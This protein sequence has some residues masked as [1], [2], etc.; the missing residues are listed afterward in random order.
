MRGDRI[1]HGTDTRRMATLDH[2][3]DRF[4]PQRGTFENKGEERTVLACAECNERRGAERVASMPKELIW[5]K[6]HSPPRAAQLGQSREMV[7]S[8][9]VEPRFADS[10]SAVLPS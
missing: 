8:L 1:L 3:D 7:D 5:Q 6:C 9:G 10:K 2:L 4:S